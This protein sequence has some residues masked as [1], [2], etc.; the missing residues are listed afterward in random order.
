[1]HSDAVDFPKTGKIPQ[2][3][4][5]LRPKSYPDFMM[6]CDKQIYT[7]T[8][9]IG[10]LFRQCRSL[11]R[12]QKQFGVKIVED[13]DFI[14]PS[15]DANIIEDAKR[16]RDQYIVKVVE[17][18]D[19]Y[20]IKNENE[21]I[22]GLIQS[23]KVIS[24]RLKDEKFQVGQIVAKKMCMI[25]KKTREM[26]FGEFGGE[27]NVS[28]EDVRVLRKASAWYKVT[29]FHG[30]NSSRKI[31][32]FPWTIYDV[33]LLLKNP[34]HRGLQ[35][36]KLEVCL[37]DFY[38]FSQHMR[39]NRNRV[40]DRLYTD[41]KTYLSHNLRRNVEF[42][43]IGL[44][45]C[46]LFLKNQNNLNVELPGLSLETINKIFKKH[47]IL[48]INKPIQDPCYF[49]S[50]TETAYVRF[51][52]DSRIVNLS[53][54]AE[55]FFSK[56]SVLLKP[57][58]Q[59]LLDILQK[60]LPFDSD[61]Y[62]FCDL[63]AI[64]IVYYTWSNNNFSVK[65]FESHSGDQEC[66]KC[67][68]AVLSSFILGFRSW[69]L[70]ACSVLKDG[71]DALNITLAVLSEISEIFIAAY[72]KIAQNVD[73]NPFIETVK[74]YGTDRYLQN[75]DDYGDDD[76]YDDDDDFYRIFPLPLN[77]W[78]TIKNSETYV[79]A[80]L[81]EKTGAE[82]LFYT[83]ESGLNR[84][85]AWGTEMALSGVEEII[86][87]IS[88]TSSTFN[89][90]TESGHLIV[91]NAYSVVFQGGDND[92]RLTFDRYHGIHHKTHYARETFIPKLM[93]VSSDKNYSEF[94]VRF[95][96]QWNVLRTAYSAAF[97]GDLFLSISFGTLYVM[98]IEKYSTL[99]VFE[100]NDLFTTL[101]TRRQHLRQMTKGKNKIKVPYTFSF[102]PVVLSN[103]GKMRTVLERL[104]FTNDINDIKTKISIRFGPPNFLML[105]YDENGDV[106]CLKLSEIKWLMSTLVPA[107]N[108]KQ[109]TD[110]RF[111]LQS[112]RDLDRGYV[113]RKY[114][115]LLTKNANGYQLLSPCG[116]S[117]A[118]EKVVETYT[119]TNW[120]GGYKLMVE[121]AAVTEL[122]Q[123]ASLLVRPDAPRLEVLLLPE[124]PRVTAS[125]EELKSNTRQIQQFALTLAAEFENF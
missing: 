31:L 122:T 25:Q 110:I 97:H 42:N 37:N 54:A 14:L 64:T 108:T 22:T 41:A 121:V 95:L 80:Q 45:S 109:G 73:N 96:Q 2:I 106:C 62:V 44:D 91:E 40:L 20:G 119:S 26:F 38:S 107:A 60:I 19:L 101:D 76:V 90:H 111:K 88:K 49:A 52:I 100:L 53:K 93:H 78:N 86:N 94:E 66:A 24:G 55:R 47:G 8:K 117:Y 39:K 83:T 34:S 70:N 113:N 43:V 61:S 48:K 16:D 46:G 104:G 105:D 114:K 118:R 27:T 85:Q 35:P 5:D 10:Q 3:D 67:L 17:L 72:H 98:D 87:N 33:L 59:F 103:K 65:Q 63:I 12:M 116:I 77:V 99:N 81:C 120:F 1:M 9:I 36:N 75:I 82:I 71:F 32:S 15:I 50:K 28:K 102:Q 11:L 68:L 58:V 29:Y 89:L 69:N 115:K 74:A 57:I 79:E 6:K 124:I 123:N 7:S 13:E 56:R 125:D 30:R 23:V 112:Y 21:A 84:I 4:D 92:S 18:L 51:I